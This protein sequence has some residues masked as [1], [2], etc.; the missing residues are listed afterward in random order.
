MELV[1]HIQHDVPDALVGDAGRLRQVL[2]NLVGNAIKFTEAGEVAVRV[3]SQDSGQ[4]APGLECEAPFDSCLL[5]FTVRDTGIGIPPEKQARIFRAFE[6]EDTST[7]RRY[8]GTGLGLTIAAQLVDLMGGTMSVDS[9]P[10]RGST[11]AF[12]AKF[13]RQPHPPE[14][15]AARSPIQLRNLLVLVIDDNATNCRILEELLRNWQMEPVAVNNGIAAMNTL[16]DAVTR[17]R[18]YPLVLLDARMPDTDGMVLAAKIRE[19]PELAATRII[20]LTSGDMPSNLAR[21]RELRIDA[22][23]LKPVQQ[24]ELLET[25]HRVLSKEEGRKAKDEG[26]R[27]KEEKE[28]PPASDSSFNLPPSTFQLNI[29]AA[30]DD[31]FS[32]QLLEQL[33]VRRGH[34]VRLA[35][36]GRKALA[37]L[38]IGGQKSEVRGQTPELGNDKSEGAKD[39]SPPSSNFEPLA[40]DHRPL[41]SDYDLLLL[42]VHMPA[43]DGFQVIQKIRERERSVG[44]HLPVIALTARSRKEDR[45][46][47]LAAG[48]DDFL[49]KPIQAPDLWAAIDR[50]MS[51]KNE[52]ERTA[53]KDEEGRMKDETEQTPPSDSYSI[54]HPS[55]LLDARVLLAACGGDAAILEKICQAFRVGLPDQVKVVRDASRDGNAVRLREAAHKLSGMVAAFSTVAGKVASDVE[56]LAARKQLEQARPLVAQLESIADELIRLTNGLSIDTLRE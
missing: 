36:N 48:M 32:A 28:N 31:D 3:R 19:R 24:D 52:G 53:S 26:G 20:L 43:L 30:E 23:L 54:L 46:R 14:Q 38:G 56:D 50:A 4:Q 49:A 34:Q 35:N 47:C 5:E 41:T 22:H 37:L 12:T 8:G 15:V 13:G 18:P 44:G 11:F 45:E 29:L 6:Q 40:S 10:R 39:P 42:D 27:I 7:T 51:N 25:I 2:L 55:S 1:C 21:L 17:G 9:E 16:W 33:L